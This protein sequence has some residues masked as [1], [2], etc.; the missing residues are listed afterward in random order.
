MRTSHALA[1]IAALTAATLA[2]PGAHAQD[3]R[4]HSPRYATPHAGLVLGAVEPE[5]AAHTGVDAH[6]STLVVEIAKGQAAGPRTLQRFDIITRVEGLD[7]AGLTAVAKAIRSAQPGDTLRLTVIRAG[8]AVPVTLDITE[9]H[10]ADPF[11][12][13]LHVPHVPPIPALPPHFEADMQ[14]L[15]ERVATIQAEALRHQAH[16]LKEMQPFLDAVRMHADAFR[17][18]IT[19]EIRA[20]LDPDLTRRIVQELERRALDP[21]TTRT[22]MRGLDSAIDTF[23]RSLGVNI[24]ADA[25]RLHDDPDKIARSLA[26]ALLDTLEAA[27]ATVTDDTRAAIESAAADATGRLAG[28]SH[29]LSDKARQALDAMKQRID[30]LRPDT[31]RRAP[32]DARPTKTPV[33]SNT[34]RDPVA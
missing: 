5:L 28:W 15:R 27:G 10:H 32:D 20:A 21:E 33:P 6:S 9:A 19:A 14:S 34:S 29:P 3:R 11:P 12:P 18:T 1:A 7:S 13:A 16:V 4:P 26:G 25:V 17:E 2:T 31:F 23:I 22:L 8:K 30:S 24:D